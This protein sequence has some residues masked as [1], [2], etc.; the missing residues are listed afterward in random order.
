M[1]TSELEYVG[2]WL[3]LWASLIDTLLLGAVTA[4]LLW[5]LY[6]SGYF[7]AV[8]A[9]GLQGPA[10]FLISY[11]LP[12]VA[13]V[14]FWVA[15]GATP[16]KMAIGATVVDAE[17]GRTPNAAQAI[18]RYLGYFVSVFAAGLGFAWIAWDRRKQGFH[19]K[20]AGTVVVRPRRPAAVSFPGAPGA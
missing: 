10:D 20:L 18:G 17:T 11:L 9:R 19:D 6:G 3:R 15:R 4:P 5:Y 2:F 12:A 8:G 13:A 14:G 1:D 7:Q 16:G